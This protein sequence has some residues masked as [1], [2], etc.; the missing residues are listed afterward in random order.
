LGWKKHSG[1]YILADTAKG[2]SNDQANWLSIADL[3]VRA[4]HIARESIDPNISTELD[5]IDIR[6]DKGIVKFVYLH[7]YWGVQLDMTTGELL[8]IE[9]RRSDFIERLHDGTLLDLWFGVDG[10][11][12]KVAYTSVLGI[13]LLIFTVTGFWLWLGPIQFRRRNR[14]AVEV[15]I[16]T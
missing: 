6:P 11:Y 16:E 3:T 1:G 8:K 10:G 15:P 5:R 14:R 7:N 12:L 2:R 9:S 4:D 13:A